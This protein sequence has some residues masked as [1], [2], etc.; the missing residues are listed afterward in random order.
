MFWV[1]S[2]RCQTSAAGSSPDPGGTFWRTGRGAA[3]WLDG[4]LTADLCPDTI[5]VR[6]HFEAFGPESPHTCYCQIT[7]RI[8]AE[9]SL[10]LNDD[11]W[12]FVEWDFTI[13][14]E[15]LSMRLYTLILYLILYPPDNHGH[16]ANPRCRSRKKV[17]CS[18]WSRSRSVV[19][20]PVPEFQINSKDVIKMSSF[21][22]H[23]CVIQ[24]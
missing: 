16:H 2:R 22:R 17:N 20:G 8:N 14:Y 23:Q 24:M 18:S 1:F 3:V 21:V 6:G 5:A 19:R 11:C 4:V 10:K 9:S 13:Y 12:D 15:T 7:Y